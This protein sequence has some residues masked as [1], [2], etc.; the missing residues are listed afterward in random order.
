MSTTAVVSPLGKYTYW[1]GPPSIVKQ[2]PPQSDGRTTH[3]LASKVWPHTSQRPVPF[4][5]DEGGTVAGVR[6]TTEHAP[7]V[8][9]ASGR[10]SSISFGSTMRT[11]GSDGAHE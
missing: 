2:K 7:L 1:R 8:R 9:Q 3:R 10:S 4:G 6:A 5:I 11:L